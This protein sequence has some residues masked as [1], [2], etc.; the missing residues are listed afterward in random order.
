MP[1]LQRSGRR[2]R[3]AGGAGRVVRDVSGATTAV[4][5]I[6]VSRRVKGSR[7]RVDLSPRVFEEMQEAER[8]RAAW[9]LEHAVEQLRVAHPDWRV[10]GEKGRP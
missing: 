4:E 6:V 8:R 1:E 3:R 7:R 10:V 2:A 5:G 9:A